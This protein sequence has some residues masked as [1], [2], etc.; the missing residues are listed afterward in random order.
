MTQGSVRVLEVIRHS[1][2]ERGFPPTF[3]EIAKALGFSST[4][5]V[6]WHLRALETAGKLSRVPG[7]ARGIRLLER[8]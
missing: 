3:R 5:T 7:V 2:K 1:V 6:R 4:N 8:G